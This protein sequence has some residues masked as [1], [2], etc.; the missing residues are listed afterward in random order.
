MLHIDGW[1]FVKGYPGSWAPN[2]DEDQPISVETILIL[3][4]VKSVEQRQVELD[5]EYEQERL[6]LEKKVNTFV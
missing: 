2:D 1:Q 3:Q 4:A 6:Q 5:N